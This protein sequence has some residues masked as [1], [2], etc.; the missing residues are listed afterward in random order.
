MTLK[1]ESLLTAY[2]DGELE[3]DE[4]VSIESALLV[5]P[6][7]ARR[8]RQLSEVHEL[9]AGL[10]RPVLLVDLTEEIESRIGPRPVR[11]WP[12][13]R[14][15]PPR[16]C[17]QGR[18]GPRSGGFGVDRAGPGAAAPAAGPAT[19]PRGEIAACGNRQGAKIGPHARSRAGVRVPGRHSR[20]GSSGGASDSA[21]LARKQRDAR[22][23]RIGSA[24]CSI[25]PSCAGCSS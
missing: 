16:L 4:R 6:E 2:L 8:L 20:V 10:P 12:G 13:V 14:G 18:M 11:L 25:V 22:R 24:R 9:I 23:R 19:R 15:G 21:A 7:L 5:D 1:D 17:R 3:P